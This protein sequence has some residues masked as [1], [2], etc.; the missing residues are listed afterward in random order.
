MPQRVQTLR[1]ST[2]KQ[3]PAP[4]TREVGELYVNFPDLQL[5]VVDAAKNPTDLL[6]VRF[7]STT[8]DYIYGDF[9]VYAGAGYK[10]KGSIPAGPLTCRYSGVAW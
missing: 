4:G 9:V 10:S 1:S 6:A 2:K 8:T 5:G 7:F 3:R